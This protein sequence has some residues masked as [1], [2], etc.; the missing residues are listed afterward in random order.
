[1]AFG[2]YVNCRG[3]WTR[4]DGRMTTPLNLMCSSVE[5]YLDLT[6]HCVDE[7]FLSWVALVDYHTTCSLWGSQDL[8][9]R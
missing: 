7:S 4:G 5:A 3:G 9:V 2:A 1:M 6:F 8:N